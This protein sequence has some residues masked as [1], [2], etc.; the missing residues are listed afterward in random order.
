MKKFT[1]KNSHLYKNN[2]KLHYKKIII[3]ALIYLIPMFIIVFVTL[4]SGSNETLK[5]AIAKPVIAPLEYLK[6]NPT[7]NELSSYTSIS[8]ILRPIFL[9][10]PGI[11]AC[12]IIMLFFINMTYTRENQTGQ[13]AVWITSPNSKAKILLS[14][15]LFLYTSI[16]LIILPQAIGVLS[17]AA[18]ASDAHHFFW[19]LFGSYVQHIFVIIFLT[20]LYLLIAV[21][22]HEKTLVGNFINTG[23][24]LY[25]FLTWVL[26]FFYDAKVFDGGMNWITSIKFLFFQSL[27]Y[28]TLKFEKTSTLLVLGEDEKH[29]YT[30]AVSGETNTGLIIFCWMFITWASLLLVLLGLIIFKHKNLNI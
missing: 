9:G 27:M 23:I 19:N 26:E 30:P 15:I 8:E 20:T 24:L 25:I 3:F 16:C 1:F 28:G 10:G 17:Y 13:I 2:F 7:G 21:L 14:K 18:T 29:F 11:I 5:K 12:S 22:C 4:V 6:N